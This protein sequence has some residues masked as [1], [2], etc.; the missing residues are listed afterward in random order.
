MLLPRTIF[1]LSFLVSFFG[2]CGR[3]EML[4]DL[5]QWHFQ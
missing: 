2:T 1:E 3:L 5:I 4:A